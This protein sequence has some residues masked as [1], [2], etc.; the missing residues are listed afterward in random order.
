MNHTE[1]ITTVSVIMPIKMVDDFTKAAIYSIVDQSEKVFEI[2]IVCD[3]LAASQVEQIIYSENLNRDQNI[4]IVTPTLKG[5]SA[6]LNAGINASVGRYVARMDSDDI[7]EKDRIEVQRKILDDNKSIF[8][9]SSNSSVI[10][11]AGEIVKQNLVS[12]QPGLSPIGIRLFIQ[13]LIIHPT[14]MMRRECIET[15]GGYS[16]TASEDYDLWIRIFDRYSGSIYIINQPLLKYRQHAQ[17]LST[18]TYLQSNVAMVASLFR[19]LLV[20][21]RSIKFFAIALLFVK[22]FLIKIEIKIWKLR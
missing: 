11:S 8:V 13:N 20:Y 17:Q 7:A 9:L 22:I 12:V 18:K 2:I 1:P 19:S 14:V 10:N 15:L 16:S 5:I 6:A 21:P 3:K 4:K